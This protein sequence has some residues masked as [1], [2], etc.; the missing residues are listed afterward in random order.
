MPDVMGALQR[1]RSME[2]EIQTQLE[3]IERLHRIANRAKNS[4]ACAAE[5]VEKLA[6]LERELNSAIDEMV[7][8]K[9]EALR[10]IS[11]LS[12]EERSVIEGYYILAKNW[13]QLAFD[14]Y[15]SDR[16]VFL[17]RKS[18]LSKLLDRFGGNPPEN[19]DHKTSR[20]VAKE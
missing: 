6:G 14:L 8:A 16:R 3:H 11:Y 18:G 1:A 17:L 4:S 15:M 2:L 19:T 10:Y 12:G 20:T 9:R 13:Q 5:T 7:D